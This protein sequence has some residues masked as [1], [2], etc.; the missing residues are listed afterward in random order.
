MDESNIIFHSH[1]GKTYAH[2]R[3]PLK[4]LKYLKLVSWCE[5]TKRGVDFLSLGL[6]CGVTR[7]SVPA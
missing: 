3:F 4:H 6:W 2:V 5:D 1:V 7:D